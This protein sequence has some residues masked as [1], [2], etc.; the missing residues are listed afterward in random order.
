MSRRSDGPPPEPAE[1]PVIIRRTVRVVTIDDRERV[2][3]FA[4]SDPGLP[5]RS[6]W[7]VPGGGMDPGETEA[8]TAVRELAEETGCRVAE[9]QLLGPI[10]H[11]H[12]VHGYSDQVVDIVSESFYAVRVPAFTVDIAGHTEDEQ[13]T[14]TGH[15]WW[16]GDE[17]GAT[18]DWLWP[19]CL[20]DL[21]ERV[22][23]GDHQLV[24]LGD[25]EE[26]TLPA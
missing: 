1:R 9:G 7:V 5:D 23:A 25:M 22:L 19:A 20:P 14:L 8:G 3:L 2:L 24:E 4:D 21:V 6:W 16:T 10:A 13:L 12:V 18:D 15:R 26:S 11:R 17:L